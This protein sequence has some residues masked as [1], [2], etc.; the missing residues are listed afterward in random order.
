MKR[1]K[2]LNQAL[3]QRKK[4]TFEVGEEKQIKK[5]EAEEIAKDSCKKLSDVEKAEKVSYSAEIAK[6]EAE[7]TEVKVEE[8]ESKVNLSEPETATLP[9]ARRSTSPSN[10]QSADSKLPARRSASPTNI[11]A[12][13][14][15]SEIE[16][17]ASEDEEEVVSKKK[18]P[19]PVEENSPSS[20]MSE[21]V[22]ATKEIPSLLL[23]SP[24]VRRR[25][26]E[27]PQSTSVSVSASIRLPPP[28]SFRPPPPPVSPPVPATK[29]KV[30][31]TKEE[32]SEEEEESEWE[33]E[34]QSEWEYETE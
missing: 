18:S 6:T 26:E 34:T 9:A 24:M 8:S 17:E 4:N 10:N 3:L 27:A 30:L 7:E 32:S 5:V 14:S 29:A 15:S 11:S 19:V 23:M 33:Y 31:L 28:P 21:P 22:I 13:E 2:R 25:G 1:R 16:W 20:N 12:S